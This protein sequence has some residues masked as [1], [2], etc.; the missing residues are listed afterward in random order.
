MRTRAARAA[1]VLAAAAVLTGG[2][3]G[4]GAAQPPSHPVAK[5]SATARPSATAAQRPPS[6]LGVLGRFRAGVRWLRFTEPAHAGPTGQ[7][8][9][10]RTLRVQVW[11]PLS[12]A[13]GRPVAG[14]L[15]LIA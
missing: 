4:S 1:A 10:P 2:C 14:P 13:A 5:P 8:L 12:G 11:Y 7:R 6:G 3:A 9:G 15:P